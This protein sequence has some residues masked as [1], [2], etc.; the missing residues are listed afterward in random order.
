MTD[1]KPKPKEV[2]TR[3]SRGPLM[4]I[5]HWPKERRP[6]GLGLS[7]KDGINFGVGF[8]IGGVVF[9]ILAACFIFM[10]MAAFG[11]S[12]GGLF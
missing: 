12:L 11:V 4:T 3:P 5:A 2:P 9:S 1:D 10:A 7:V 6:E 8:W